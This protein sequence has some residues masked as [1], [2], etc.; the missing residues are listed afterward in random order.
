MKKVIKFSKNIDDIL[1]LK[2]DLIKNNKINLKNTLKINKKFNK[3]KFRK[4]CIIC[5][6]TLRNIDFISHNIPYA[7]CRKCGHLNGMRIMNN[8]FNESIYSSNKGKNFS[9]I[10]KKNYM[11]R[12]NKIYFPKVEFLKKVLKKE[13]KILDFGCGAGHFVKSCEKL[14]IKAIGIDPNQDLIDKGNK[15]LKKNII[16]K[17]NFNESVDEITFTSADVIS[18]IFVLEHLEDPNKIFR[19]FNKSNAKYIYISVPLFS[20]SV[21]IENIFQKIYPRQLGGPHTNLYSKD[22]LE[23]IAKKYKLEIIGEWW[24]GTD[25]SDLYRNL[26]LSSN[27]KTSFY[28]D[29][30]DNLFLKQINSFQNVLDKSKLSS[31]VH[32]V[33][34]KRRVI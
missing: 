12:V 13:I 18:L 10:Y 7:I 25:F 33:L 11:E 9:S 28:K 21:F 1:S 16:K 6:F 31:E 4:K 27:Y 23:F 29:K 15:Y 24:F 14:G 30:F 17:L 3:L 2:K 8:K 22:S 26:L 19:A 20:F 5:K 32:L 34:K